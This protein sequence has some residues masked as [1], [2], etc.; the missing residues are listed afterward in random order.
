ML[1]LRRR[2]CEADSM[3]ASYIVNQWC[4]T[5]Y[6]LL[7]LYE[8]GAKGKIDRICRWKDKDQITKAL[9]KKAWYKYACIL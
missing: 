9:R 3:C 2:T 7:P 1:N 5:L 8:R 4:V 6:L